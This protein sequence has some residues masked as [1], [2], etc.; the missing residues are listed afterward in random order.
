MILTASGTFMLPAGRLGDMYGHRRCYIAAWTW[1]A[2]ASLLAGVSVFSNSF[3]FYAVCRGLQGMGTSML[4]PSSLAILG[5]VYKDGPR[6]NLAFSLFAAGAPT[7]FTVWGIISGLITESLWWPWIF[8]VTAIACCT[9][10]CAGFLTIPHLPG[11]VYRATICQQQDTPVDKSPRRD[12]DW[13]G[14]ATGVLGLVLFNVAWNQAPSV[15]WAAPSSLG[16]LITGFLLLL[17][18]PFVEKRASRPLIPVDRLS[19]D[20]IFVLATMSLAWSSFGILV[21]YLV[22]FLTR[23]R[24]E[25]IL[26]TGVQFIPVPIAGFAASY[27]NAF[28]LARRVPSADVLAFSCIWFIVGNLLLATMPVHQSFWYQVFW[29]NVL[30]PFGIDL[31]FPASTLLMSQ[32]VPPEQQGI[33]A[34]L[35]ATVVYYSQSIGLGIAGTVQSQVSNGSILRGYRGAFFTGVGMSGFAFLVSMWPVMKIHVLKKGL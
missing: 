20:S 14:T 21:F 35:I 3:I 22:N 2:V 30:A 15:G 11:E 29:V 18:F 6:K 12:F 8:W 10:A 33:A 4:L 34:S 25:S 7:G 16:T 31:S 9:L 28:L 23:L 27:L 26:I 17:A 1:L 5:S 19:K 13:A 32:L 24:G